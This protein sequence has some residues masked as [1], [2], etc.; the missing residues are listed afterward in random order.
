MAK[1][2]ET[3]TLADRCGLHPSITD[4]DVSKVISLVVFRFSQ[5]H[6]AHPVHIPVPVRCLRLSAPDRPSSS[7]TPSQLFRSARA[8]QGESATRL[9]PRY[10]LLLD[11]ATINLLF[12]YFLHQ[13]PRSSKAH[14][15]EVPRFP[16]QVGKSRRGTVRDQRSRAKS[17]GHSKLRK[18]H[19]ESHKYAPVDRAS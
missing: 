4:T 7:S 5:Y 13:R 16:R 9:S 14:S 6:M 10:H 15:P 12:S 8:G 1:L 18:S 17:L 3:S 11:N 2:T 19:Y